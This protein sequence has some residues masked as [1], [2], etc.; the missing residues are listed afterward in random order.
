M[1][2]KSVISMLQ[3][4]GVNLDEPTLKVIK[5]LERQKIVPENQIADLLKEKINA[6]R[7]LL[8]RLN[9]QGLAVYTKKRD[10]KK[11]WWYLYYWALDRGRIN[12]LYINHKKK[13]LEKKREQLKEEQRF[14]FECKDCNRRF[15]YED[16]LDYDFSC[17]DC[18]EL[19]TE[20]TDGRIVRKLKREIADLEK[21]LEVLLRKPKPKK[22]KPA[23]KPPK[24]PKKKPKKKLRK[25]VKKKVKKPKPKKKLKKVK[26]K[27]KA[28][29]PKPKKKKKKP[30]KSI[31]KSILSKLFRRKKK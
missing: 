26:P 14:V 20:M 30:K 23:K 27:K 9:I 2:A 19:L 15:L 17:P 4:I 8:Y 1:V 10:P 29:K 3:E 6:A 12:T 11:K 24:K 7:K 25:P 21:E 31:K 28:K 18:G 16:S 22:K 5:I 13:L